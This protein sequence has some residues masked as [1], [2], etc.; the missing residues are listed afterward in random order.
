MRLWSGT[1]YAAVPMPISP[2]VA[3]LCSNDYQSAYGTRD[4]GELNLAGG[5]LI[6]SEL[7]C[8]SPQ[9]ERRPGKMVI[10][11]EFRIMLAE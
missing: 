8:R 6:R 4:N 9:I 10:R 3:V 7:P 2:A 11:A 1:G 5:G